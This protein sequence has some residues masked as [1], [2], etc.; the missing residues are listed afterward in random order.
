MFGE[1]TSKGLGAG[2]RMSE[3]MDQARRWQG[4]MLDAMGWGPVETP[5]RVVFSAPG[6][7]LKGYSQSAEGPVLLLVPATI[8]RA[9]IWDLAPGAS[10]VRHALEQGLR[11]YLVQWEDPEETS[12]LAGY[13]DRFILDCMNAIRADTGEERIFVAGH[14]LGGMFSA[15]F[16]SMHPERVKGL[17]V[18]TAPL[19]FDFAKEAGALGP[20]IGSV[21]RAGLL[22]AGS[23]NL[24]GSFL[25]AVSFMASPGAF[26]KE[27]WEDWFASLPDK[28][29]V[30]SHMR[31]ERWS[32]DELRLARQLVKDIVELLY[33]KDGFMQGTLM[34]DGKRAA[35]GQV[36]APLVTVM[37]ERCPVVPPA[38]ILPFHEA[39][40]STEKTLLRYQG[41]TGVAI[42]HVGALVGRNAHQ[43]LWPEIFGWIQAHR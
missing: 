9:Y 42:Q 7:T 11:P 29:A 27:R 21:Y 37:D 38:A 25:S 30:Q 26:G 33:R 18:V 43:R 39:A 34:L 2:W 17:V 24:P 19:H 5:S 28:D 14:S 41:D 8:K 16:T 20:V 12:G 22:D 4:Q 36:A 3:Q 31:V 23:G 10:V 32:F 13:A 6:V 35:A 1:F 15:V 40:A